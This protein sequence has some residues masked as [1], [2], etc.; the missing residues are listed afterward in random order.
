ISVQR[1]L[2]IRFPLQT[3]SWR[4]KKETAFAVCLVFWAFLVTI[5]AIFREENYPNKLWTCYERCKNQ[6]LKSQFIAILL[7]LGFLTPLLIIVF[8]SS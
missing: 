2:A 1:Y 8:C 7:F 3:R 5:C 6:R 4:K